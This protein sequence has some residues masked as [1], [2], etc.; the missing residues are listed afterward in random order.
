MP[1]FEDEEEKTTLP[2]FEDDE[3]ET[4]LPGFEDDEEGQY[5]LDSKK[6]K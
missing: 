1:G 2:G 5:C 6:I 4:I 3:D